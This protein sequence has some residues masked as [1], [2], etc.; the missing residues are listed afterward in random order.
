M[1]RI[2]QVSDTH[3]NASRLAF[4]DNWDICADAIR[5]LRP[6]LVIN[7]GD[8]SY[9]GADSDE[10]LSFAHGRME[11]LGLP[12]LA[13]P[14]NHDI[15]DNPRADGPPD[16]QEIV[17]AR[18]DRYTGVFGADWWRHDI[19]GWRLVGI[20]AQ[21]FGSEMAEEAEQWDFLKDAVAGGSEGRVVLFLHRPLFAHDAA[22]D[23]EAM[24]YVNQPFK[25]RLLQLIRRYRPAAV[26]SGHTHQW[27]SVRDRGT[28]YHWC[29]S[30]AF[31]IADV[32]QPLIGEKCLG[33]LSLE[34]ND[35][36][37]ADAVAVHLH[38]PEGLVHHEYTGRSPKTAN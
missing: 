1:P 33:F 14:G 23:G 13:I 24:R 6:D 37:G 29:P 25:N 3:L 10:D 34:L 5:A 16:A 15:G 11:A 35:G 32:L 20:N 18:R 17:P 19:A 26:L 8:A 38:R 7:T 28:G 31:V 30:S 12:W 2:V 36:A 21:L 22:V 27:L 4:V 9:N